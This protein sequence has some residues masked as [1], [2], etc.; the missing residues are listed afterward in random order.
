MISKSIKVLGAVLAC[1]LASVSYAQAKEDVNIAI[2]TT[3][4]PF[5][6]KINGELKGF[7]VDLLKKIAELEGLTINWSEM[8]FDGMIP[9][10]QAGQADVAA[11]GFF[12]TDARKQVIDYSEPHFSEGNILAVPFDSDIKELKDISGKQIVAKRGSAGFI[13]AQKISQQYGATLKTLDDESSMYLQV[14]TRNSDGLVNDSAVLAYKLKLE[15]DHPTLRT[16]GEVID[17]SD[18]A[19]AFSKGSPL[20]ARFTNALHRM[21]ASGDYQ[22]IYS[23]YFTE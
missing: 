20:A 23:L 21:K 22:R 5:E 6:Y 10:L 3:A 2:L 18:V 15:G 1:T 17:K 4:A 19:F 13:S 7:E 11:A 12:V 9:A 14:Q 16:V 8:K